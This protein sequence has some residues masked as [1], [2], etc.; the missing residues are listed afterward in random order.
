MQI[1]PKAGSDH[2]RAQQGTAGGAVGL[3]FSLKDTAGASQPR[4]GQAGLNDDEIGANRRMS[5]SEAGAGQGSDLIASQA[6][7]RGV[8]AR[9]R[10]RGFAVAVLNSP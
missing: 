4:T 10:E 1:H 2:R 8:A 3:E 9:V 6:E 5:K 7:P